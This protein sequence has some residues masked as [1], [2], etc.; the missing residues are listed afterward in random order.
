MYFAGIVQDFWAK[1]VLKICKVNRLNVWR[2]S[3]LS[4]LLLNGTNKK[5]IFGGILT[6]AKESYRTNL[7]IFRALGRLLNKSLSNFQFVSYSMIKRAGCLWGCE[8]WWSMMNQLEAPG[9]KTQPYVNE[10]TQNKAYNRWGAA[11]GFV[12]FCHYHT[13][14]T[15]F[16]FNVRNFLSKILRLSPKR[17]N[18]GRE[19]LQITNKKKFE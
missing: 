1:P 18:F 17:E 10:N 9:F 3:D 5:K 8:V 19:L 6:E 16:F 4:V 15:T 13:V 12:L 2:L 14:T 11:S 7:G